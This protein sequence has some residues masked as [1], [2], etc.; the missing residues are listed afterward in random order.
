MRY[1]P[2]CGPVV[3]AL[4]SRDVLFKGWCQSSRAPE[5]RIHNHARYMHGK[6]TNMRQC[7][8]VLAAGARGRISIEGLSCRGDWSNELWPDQVK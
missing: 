3:D 2:A 8:M 1:A 5:A 7:D 6:D 4:G